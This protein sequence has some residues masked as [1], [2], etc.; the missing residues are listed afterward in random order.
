MGKIRTGFCS[1]RR[2]E[3]GGGNGFS[4]ASTK[5]AVLFIPQEPQTTQTHSSQLFPSAGLGS[6]S[7]IGSRRVLQN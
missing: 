3:Y 5:C 1:G 6:K 7:A 4:I 2:G